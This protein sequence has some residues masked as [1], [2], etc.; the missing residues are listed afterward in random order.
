MIE[1]IAEGFVILAIC[2]ALAL[3]LWGAWKAE[4]AMQ[5]ELEREKLRRQTRN[6]MLTDKH[7]ARLKKHN[8]RARVW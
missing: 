6:A 5:E 4:Q 1:K 8:R 7:L 2:A 3:I